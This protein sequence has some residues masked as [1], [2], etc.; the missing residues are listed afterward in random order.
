Y[1]GSGVGCP[2][3]APQ[4]PWVRFAESVLRRRSWEPR[5]RRWGVGIAD[6]GFRIAEWERG[7]VAGRRDGGVEGRRNQP[8]IPAFLLPRPEGTRHSS[9]FRPA[10]CPGGPEVRGGRGRV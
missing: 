2:H 6:F 7:R 4:E 1:S 5:G 10:G 9:V 3:R 8:R